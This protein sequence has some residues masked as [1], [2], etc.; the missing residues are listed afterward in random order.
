MQPKFWRNHKGKLYHYRKQGRYDFFLWFDGELSDYIPLPEHLKDL[1]YHPSE[2]FDDYLEQHL[3]VWKI[4]TENPGAELKQLKIVK[5]L[6]SLFSKGKQML[7]L[8]Q[9][10]MELSV[11]NQYYRNFRTGMQPITLI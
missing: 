11:V 3:R 2:N 10:I 8:E 5:D 9:V 1:V 4:G 7:T 6:L